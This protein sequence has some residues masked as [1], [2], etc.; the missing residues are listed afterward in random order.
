MKPLLRSLLG[1]LFLASA[2]AGQGPDEVAQTAD[3]SCTVCHPGSAKGLAQSVHHALA[4]RERSCIECHAEADAH[5]NSALDPV[6]D[7]VAPPPVAADSCASCHTAGEFPVHRG[8]HPWTRG[9]SLRDLED[10]TPVTA[11]EDEGVFGMQWS[12][13]V[14]AGVRFLNRGGSR[15]RYRTDIN[16]DRGF[17]VTEVD[18]EGR[19]TGDSWADL[20]AVRGDSLG[21]PFQSVDAEIEKSGL[22]EVRGRYSRSDVRYRAS[23]DYHRVDRTTQETGFNVSLDLGDA[24]LFGSTTRLSQDGF[25]LTN[26][27]GNQNLTPLTTVPGVASPRRLDS[28]VSEIGLHTT[29]W[30]ASVTAAVDYRDERQRDRWTYSRT[31]AINPAFAES[32]DFRSTSTLRG[33]G[34]RWTIGKQIEALDLE[35]DGR[36]FDLE[37]RTIGRGTTTGFDVSDFVTSTTSDSAGDAQTWALDGRAVWD[38]ADRASLLAEVQ[39]LDHEEQLDLDQTDIT[40]FPTL[41]TTT[42][43]STARRQRTTQRKLTG[44]VELDVEPIEGLRLAGGYLWSRE[45]LAVPDLIAGDNDFRRGLVKDDGALAS[46]EWRPD[47][48]W[49][50]GADYRQTDQGG[51]QPHELIAQQSRRVKGRV[52]Y[53]TDGFWAE[54]F[55]SDRQRENDVSTS[56]HRSYST[57]VTASVQRGEDVDIYASWVFSD[58]DSRTLTN[59]YFDPDPNPQPTLVGFDG[60]THTASAGITL[61]PDANVTWRLDGVYTDTRGTFDVTLFDWN[62]DLRFEVFEGGEAG[63]L[64]RLLDYEEAGAA[65]D[66]DAAITLVY[67]RQRIGRRRR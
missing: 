5:A 36:F 43:V 10:R 14:A 11:A 24:E 15:E 54:A 22:Y 26:R 39:W 32:E 2:A 12:A 6:R 40:V 41:S 8:S 53:S 29:I 35:L 59:F 33:P 34:V 57:G 28:D 37:R 38:F 3:L 31:S 52:R 25:W 21:D 49:T 67:W 47:G 63:V 16:L 58:T 7:L 9:L 46:I 56:R 18:L 4:Q 19:G 60:D 65:D 62:T 44:S 55:F 13:L 23:G 1:A 17:R 50:F 48:H 30:G 20:V 61:R 64:F 27:I 51:V 42:T 45:D 66:Y